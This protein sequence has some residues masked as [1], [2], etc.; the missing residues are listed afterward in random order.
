M[1]V[2][3]DYLSVNARV[4]TASLVLS[5]SAGRSSARCP[6]RLVAQDLKVMEGVGSAFSFVF[7]VL[8]SSCMLCVYRKSC[9]YYG[10]SYLFRCLQIY[11]FFKEV[12]WCNSVWPVL[13]QNWAGLLRQGLV[14]TGLLL[15]T[16]MAIATDGF[17]LV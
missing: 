12:G 14:D 13:K 3:F 11:F 9:C 4:S 8:L 1:I 5:C 15:E 17:S 10:F 16:G 6:C 7:R 2:C